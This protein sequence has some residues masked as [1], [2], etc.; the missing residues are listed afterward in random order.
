MFA[1]LSIKGVTACGSPAAHPPSTLRLNGG[2]VFV[3]IAVIIVRAAPFLASLTH[4]SL[5]MGLTRVS[6]TNSSRRAANQVGV[7]ITYCGS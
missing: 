2:A 7:G 1:C 3:S 5:P 6:G 4:R